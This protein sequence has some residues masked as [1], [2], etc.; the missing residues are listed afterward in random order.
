MKLHEN[1]KSACTTVRSYKAKKRESARRALGIVLALSMVITGS[2]VPMAA[3]APDADQEIHQHTESCYERTY[4]KDTGE[5][6]GDSWQDRLICGYGED[7]TLADLAVSGGD[8]AGQTPEDDETIPENPD[9]EGAPDDDENSEEKADQDAPDADE[10]S[11]S[12]GD[13]AGFPPFEGYDE[14]L[15][16]LDCQEAEA[17]H[18]HGREC[19][20]EIY[21]GTKVHVHEEA[22]GNENGELVCGKEEHVHDALC[23]ADSDKKE[24]IKKVSEMIA[25]LP[26][27]EEIWAMAE[28]YEAGEVDEES[29]GDYLL[30][31]MAQ[32]KETYDAYL[33]IDEEL[34]Q[35]VDK[36]DYLLELEMLLDTGTLEE[37]GSV[38][39]ELTGDDA[40]VEKIA[41]TEIRD[42]TAPFDHREHL[43]ECYDAA[44]TLICKRTEYGEGEADRPGDDTDPN[45]LVVRTFDSVN[46]KF[47]VE[48]KT[49][50]NNKAYKEAK[51][52]LEFVL[53]LSKDKAEF[54]LAAMSW[55]D[56]AE[57]YGPRV[58]EEVRR[59]REGDEEKEIL[60]Q[61]L[62]CYKHL[63]PKDGGQSVVPGSF[64]DNVTINVK[65]MANGDTFAPIVSAAMEYGTWD[66][67]EIGPWTD[68]PEGEEEG[69]TK[70]CW[71]DEPVCPEHNRTEKKSVRARE[72]KVS[73]AP[74]YNIQ[75]QGRSSY[76]A[77]FDFGSG[78][79]DAANKGAGQMFGRAMKLGITLQLYNDNRSKGLKGIELPDT[80]KAIEFDLKVGSRYGNEG[81]YDTSGDYGPLLWS[82]GYSGTGDYGV[83]LENGDGRTILETHR[84]AGQAPNS[85]GWAGCDNSG[86][87]KATQEGD[88]IHVTVSGYTVNV[89]NMPKRNGDWGDV[90]YGSDIGIGCFASGQIWIVQPFNRVGEGSAN[91]GPEFDIIKEPVKD[92][93]GNPVTD[94]KGN[95]LTYG[96]GAFSSSVNAM[97]LKMWTIG[98]QQYADSEGTNDSQ[99]VTS[100]DR[101]AGTLALTLPG[102]LQNRVRYADLND[103]VKKG[104]GIDDVRDGRDYATVGSEIRVMGGFTYH[105]NR[106]PDNQLYFATTLTKFYAEAIT[107]MDKDSDSIIFDKDGMA[108]RDRVTVKAY[109]A[110]KKQS[111]TKDGEVCW[112][113]END[114]ELQTTYEDE[115]EFYASMEELEKKGKKC[116]GILYCFIGP[117]PTVEEEDSDFP[118]YV[119]F[120]KVKVADDMKLAGKTYMLL[121]TTRVWTK[122]MMERDDRWRDK[123]FGK[124]GGEIWEV[125]QNEI[126]EW[127]G[128]GV[129]TNFP[130]G[131]MASANFGDA[132]NPMEGYPEG[133]NW[134]VKET[135]AE[136]GSGILGTH[137][138]DWSHWGD[139]L[140]LIGYKTEVTKHLLQK[141]G[142]V[143]KKVFNLDTNQRVVDFKLQPYVKYDNREGLGDNSEIRTTVQLVDILPEYLTY[144]EGSAYYGFD[145]VAPSE[146]GNAGT[147]MYYSQSS[148][149]GGK[150]GTVTGGEQIEPELGW[151]EEKQ[152]D[153]TTVKRRTLTWTFEDVIVGKEVPAIFYSAMIG[154]K[155]NAQ[156]DVPE[157]TTNLENKVYITSEYDLRDPSVENFKL[158]KEGIAVTRGSAKSFGKYTLQRAV[159]R[160]GEIDY[161]V[162][163]N[164]NAETPQWVSFM[165]T[166]PAD[167]VEGS[168]F[169][170]S[171]G[172]RGW[173]L[174]LNACD[175]KKIAVYYTVEDVYKDYTIKNLV[176]D[177]EDEGNPWNQIRLSEEG[178]IVT[179]D[180]IPGWTRAEVAA[181]GTISF[182]EA[183][184]KA[185]VAW[186]VF[187]QLGAGQSINIELGLLL[188]PSP[189]EAN[190]QDVYV[191][192]MSTGGDIVVTETPTVKRT[193]EGLTWLDYNRDGV[194][195]QYD[196]KEEPK[197]D[198]IRVELLK[199]RVGGDPGKEEDYVVAHYIAPEG[200]EWDEEWDEEASRILGYRAAEGEVVITTG[201]L[202]NLRD[203]IIAGNPEGA[204]RYKFLELPPGTY[205]VRFTGGDETDENRTE[206]AKA[207]HAWKATLKDVWGDA[208]DEIDSD[209]E[210]VYGGGDAELEKTVILGIVM[211]DAEVMYQEKIRLQE[212]KYHDSGFYVESA[213]DIDKVDDEGNLLAG[214]K[215]AISAWDSSA[216]AVRG[217]LT[218]TG[219]PGSYSFLQETGV[220]GEG[221]LYYIEYADNSDFVLGTQGDWNGAMSLLQKKKTDFDGQLFEIF[222]QADGTFGFRHANS[223]KWLDLDGGVTADG[224]TVHIWE[225]DGMPNANQKWRI[226]QDR[227]GNFHIQA[228]AAK[229]TEKGYLDL[230]GCNVTEG[231]QIAIYTKN[232][233]AAQKWKLVPYNGQEGK[234]QILEVGAESHET[235]RL[236]VANLVPGEYLITEM[237]APLGYMLL[238]EPVKIKVGLDGKIWVR[239]A[240]GNYSLAENDGVLVKI[241]NE[242]HQKL[243]SL[244]STGGSG[245]GTYAAAGILLM[246]APTLYFLH[247][248]RRRVRRGRRF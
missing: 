179:P 23:F 138:S 134:Y 194:Q 185:P 246:M 79:E 64:G 241:V 212:E 81:R 144:V 217:T 32:V 110:A 120:H 180:N 228:N 200:E 31:L 96:E 243:Y 139:T 226:T 77:L 107:P 90:L 210:A 87:W 235:G 207:F 147:V 167:G 169:K 119:A 41:I 178:V 78:N 174:D 220:L 196:G 20:R 227:E 222:P 168:A 151:I 65:S 192:R 166:M 153:G 82:Y 58:T 154:N 115:L 103:P 158:A 14:S 72:V 136:D 121:S 5:D 43:L 148:P 183:D 122:G 181:D 76:A 132:G 188:Y 145:G 157:G 59:F 140:L 247:D 68:M 75:I 16:A 39:G 66:N 105:T 238:K 17:D 205:G 80:S 106:E 203:G 69:F 202:V 172:L 137:N 57:G 11:V 53:P 19:Y 197:T 4:V 131:Y 162:Y 18:V 88:T 117:G 44:G 35:Y 93:N 186:V 118:Q 63:V 206:Y 29:Y 33:A 160:D 225:T 89:D 170:G 237:C 244:P 208:N 248:R 245:T 214:A 211:K 60:C 48:M 234:A 52:K 47:S 51:V 24:L 129:T 191:N 187:G 142:N 84:T 112:D 83:P 190:G 116:V 146:G 36:G 159:E 38:W 50:A 54:D 209:A 108:N 98:G 156:E 28:R 111:F 229:G 102:A 37:T 242:K 189:S 45:N 55:M 26:S 73:A 71:G 127:S 101:Y 231:V 7:G 1:K 141:S 114:E 163:Y 67:G 165:D 184:S 215:F 86:V 124:D 201:N 219:N 143:D 135:Y 104:A 6:G 128:A 240:Q 130:N 46:Y 74:K 198:G 233:T 95:V 195:D 62:T 230:S 133:Y 175:A 193:L 199:L 149:A 182:S 239:D 70:G 173:R 13:A 126:P 236:H 21:C 12:G 125:L 161:V 218:F 49:Y 34:R 2:S 176:P 9:G 177:P 27:E 150:Q 221:A 109:Y 232:N 123:V 164:N 10:D 171:Y 85:V 94:D 97:N 42:G 30:A 213:L 92:G 56:T 216:D 3:G 99:I 155:S 25:A 152:S 61:V 100:D 113:W 204:G 22:C 40:Y 223:V 8:A 15:W 224:G 91:E